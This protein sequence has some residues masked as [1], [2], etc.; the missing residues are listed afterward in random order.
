MIFSRQ[1]ICR[2]EVYAEYDA[3]VPAPLF[4]RKFLLPTR[5]QKASITICGLGFYELYLNGVRITKGRLAP[6][7]SNPDH[8]L[9]YDSYSVSEYLS[10]GENVVA[11][12][13]GNGLLNNPAGDIWDFD[14]AAFRSAPKLALALEADGQLLFEAD[15]RFRTADSPI[16]FDDYRA[17]EHYDARFEIADWM[18]LSCNDEGWEP[19]KKAACP[20][21][22][23]RLAD[24]EPIICHAEYAPVEIRRSK[25]GY[26][27]KFPYNIAGV[28]RL[29]IRGKRGQKIRLVYGEYITD[30][31]LCLKNLIFEGRTREDYM[32]IDEYVCK[33]DGEEVYVPTFTYHGFQYVSVEGITARQAKE[34]LLTALFLYSDIKR[35]GDFECSDKTVNAIQDLVMRATR[36]NFHYFPTDCPQ[37]EKNG[38]TGDAMLSAAQISFNFSAERSLREWL[39]NLRAA[40]HASGAL[41]GIAPTSGWGYEHYNGPA[42]DGAIVV[43]PYE[44]YRFSRDKSVLAENFPAMRAYLHFISNRRDADGLIGVGLGDWCQVSRNEWEYETDLRITDTLTVTELCEKAADIAHVLGEDGTLFLSFGGE[45]KAAFRRTFVREGKIAEEFATQTSVSMAIARGVFTPEELSGAKAQLLLLI[46]AKGNKFDVGV[47]GARALFRT[48][49]ALGEADLALEMV[50]TPDFPSYAYP[51]KYG[52]TT[53]W[54]GYHELKEDTFA[55]KN[56]ARI[57]SLNHHFWGDISAW[58][59]EALGGISVDFITGDVT[60]APVFPKKIEWV[61]ASREYQGGKISVSWKRTN[62]TPQVSVSAPEGVNCIVK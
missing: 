37:R 60:V 29:R 52:A 10:E 3:H 35:A 4:R 5:P 1:F 33:G 43:L 21:G 8:I 12:I 41:P 20:K 30:G 17:G 57:L 62:G 23:E 47:L 15:E 61:K 6:Y 28:C 49:A 22:E 56:E 24:C 45:L 53:L 51:L 9:Y 14:K 59:Y 42:W 39:R 44:C 16:R 38:W 54:E 31:E 18:L 2:S 19:A 7:I 32:H 25:R 46:S 40:Q 34:S 27:Y 48:L 11:V 58:F 36:S 13:L 55:F 50:T 26:L